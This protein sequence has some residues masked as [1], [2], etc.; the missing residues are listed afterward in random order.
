MTL[1]IHHV[2]LRVK[3]P[4]AS[5]LFYRDLLGLPEVRRFED[6]SGDLR[7]IWL[8]AGDALLMLE[9]EIRLP[10]PAEGSSHV[11]ALR[12]DSISTWAQRLHAA[13]I[14]VADRT[15]FTLFVRDPDGHRVGLSVYENG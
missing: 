5:A 2:A 13:G 6:G 12:V 3:D 11:L 7:S 14:E 15:D 1:R 9:R 10:S 8:E 4:E